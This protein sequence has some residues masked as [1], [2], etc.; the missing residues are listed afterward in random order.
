[1][2]G[3]NTMIIQRDGKPDAIVTRE[4]RQ[5]GAESTSSYSWRCGTESGTGR[6]IIDA[7]KQALAAQERTQVT[8][9]TTAQD[10]V[11]S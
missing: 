2:N 1:M 8:S 10:N 3:S 11:V 7:R 5:R 6:H 9:D 4:V